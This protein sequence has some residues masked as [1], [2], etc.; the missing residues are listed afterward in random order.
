MKDTIVMKMETCL[1]YNEDGFSPMFGFAAGEYLTKYDIEPGVVAGD[2]PFYVFGAIL[3]PADNNDTTIEF[4][5]NVIMA[6]GNNVAMVVFDIDNIELA[7]ILKWQEALEGVNG[8]EEIHDCYEY[9][10]VF[11]RGL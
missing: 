3:E 7:A 6:A 2:N 1:G 4:I 11:A 5:K 10:I 9:R 8:F